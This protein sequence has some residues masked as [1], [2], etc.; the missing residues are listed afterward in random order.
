MRL[1]LSAWYDGGCEIDKFIVQYRARGQLE[2]ILISNN[3]LKE[4]A[5]LLI[6]D[7]V[8]ATSYELLVI[9]QNQVGPTEVKYKFTTLDVDGKQV[10]GG[11]GSGFSIF[12][13]QLLSDNGGQDSADYADESSWRELWPNSNSRPDPASGNLVKSVVFFR[14]FLNSP[15]AL[16]C[17]LSLFILLII[18]FLF[19]KRPQ[20]GT[21]HSSSSSSTANTFTS[22]SAAT[23]KSSNSSSAALSCGGRRLS[24]D[25][26]TTI[27]GDIEAPLSVANG[28]LEES[29][30]TRFPLAH[31]QQMGTFQQASECNYQ[32]PFCANQQQQQQ[33]NHSDYGPTSHLSSDTQVDFIPSAAYVHPAYNSANQAH[34]MAGTGG[35]ANHYSL[36]SQTNPYASVQRSATMEPNLA[37]S[38]PLLSEQH[39]TDHHNHH[40]EQQQCLMQML[41]MGSRPQ[42]G[43]QQHNSYVTA[44]LTTLARNK[45]HLSANS[46]GNGNYHAYSNQPNVTLANPTTATLG[47]PTSDY[48]RPHNF[49]LGSGEHFLNDGDLAIN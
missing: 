19:H 42:P 5:S 18:I 9:A 37:T 49:G 1:H 10:G 45:S 35:G 47:R 32:S 43:D 34:S 30:A 15:L 28:S 16:L 40:H 29:P 25:A 23:N 36:A 6:R 7:L 27:M 3:I 4:Q 17:S 38:G 8:P 13:N 26:N 20:T 31:Q 21:N 39:S 2:W 12:G 11:G 41:M 14:N 22:S 46:H 48:Q 44:A 24:I 33:L